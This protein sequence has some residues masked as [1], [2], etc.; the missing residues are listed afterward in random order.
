MS[1]NN[2]SFPQIVAVYT[3]LYRELFFV[4]GTAIH[5]VALGFKLFQLLK[6]RT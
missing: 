3:L 2:R 4:K 6:Y 1:F 5:N